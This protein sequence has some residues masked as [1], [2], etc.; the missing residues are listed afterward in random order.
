[1]S[2]VLVSVG[3]CE[4]TSIDAGAITLDGPC[5]VQADQEVK[6]TSRISV[7]VFP[8]VTIRVRLRREV[9]Q[10]HWEGCARFIPVWRGSTSYSP[11]FLGVIL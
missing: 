1:M 11:C 3:G 6:M 10:G 5:N 7:S 2:D 8:A 4:Q 9:S